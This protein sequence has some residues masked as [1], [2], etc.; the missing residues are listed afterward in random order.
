MTPDD[1]TALANNN[2]LIEVARQAVENVLIE[3]RDSRI[4][5]FR[6]NGLVVREPDGKGSD[7]MRLG[8]DDAIRIGLKAI[9]SHLYSI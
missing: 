1:I 2:A 6:G 3:F 4:S 9:A 8:T 7:V 5:V